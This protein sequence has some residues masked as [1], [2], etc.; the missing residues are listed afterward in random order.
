MRPINLKSLGLS[1]YSTKLPGI[2]GKIRQTLKDFIVEE[3]SLD[4]EISYCFKENSEIKLNQPTR[5]IRL[6]LE[7]HGVETLRA[8]QILASSLKISISRIGFAGM[9]DKEAITS[10]FI[11]IKDTDLNIIKNIELG[12]IY[13]RNFNYI[14]SALNI[15]NLFGNHFII[16]IRD[17]ELST[18][19]IEGA[20]TSIKN[21]ISSGLINYFG[22]QRFGKIRPI[23]H[24]VGKAL[25]KGN[26]EDAVKIYLTKVYPDERIDASNAR[27]EL[28]E[29]WDFEKAINNFP[30]RLLYEIMMIKSLIKFP[31][32]YRKAFEALPNRLQS[33]LIYAYQSYIFNKIL[34]KRK[35]QKIAFS[36]LRINDFVLILDNQGLP[37]RA[38]VSTSEKNFTHL[39][40]LIKINKAVIAAPLIGSQTEIKED[41]IREILKEE[42]IELKDFNSKILHLNRKG[43][44]RPILFSP[45]N[46]K[47]KKIDSDE[48]YQS[49][50]KVKIDFTLKRGSYATVLLDEI[51]KNKKLES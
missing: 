31:N 30:K 32:D 51:I 5:Y 33:M 38:F 13:L 2:G 11:S 6:S 23:S 47:I 18:K 14:K 22:Q 17:L 39:E 25:L 21:E 20:I 7:K 42:G 44:F 8:I 36:D 46:F 35:E 19:K 43:G 4:N 9:K 16:V 50:N 26:Y 1:Y 29:N 24:L 45:L 34:S 37:T 41:Y 48:L 40:H 12:N 49:K 3:I 10:Q 15:G 27:I 28:K